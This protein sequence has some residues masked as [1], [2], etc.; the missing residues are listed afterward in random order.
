MGDDDRVSELWGVFLLA[1][2]MAR[3]N[4]GSFGDVVTHAAEERG[5]TLTENERMH[6]VLA[7]ARGCVAA[8]KAKGTWPK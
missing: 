4:M 7:T 2:S 6:M 1:V 3:R 8:S 5:V